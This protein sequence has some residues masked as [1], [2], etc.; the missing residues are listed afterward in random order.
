M[1]SLQ[2]E[3]SDNGTAT[4]TSEMEH[5]FDASDL[6]LSH[7]L[8]NMTSKDSFGTSELDSSHPVPP[9][10]TPVKKSHKRFA[11]PRLDHPKRKKLIDFPKKVGML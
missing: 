2:D 3:S 5:S 7:P 1:D 9:T 8:Q 11:S 10:S 4:D 6:D